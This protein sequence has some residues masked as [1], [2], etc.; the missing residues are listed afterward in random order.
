MQRCQ[1]IQLFFQHQEYEQLDDG[2]HDS[3]LGGVHSD[4]EEDNLD[5]PYCLKLSC[6]LL[7]ETVKGKKDFYIGNVYEEEV[8]ELGCVSDIDGDK[9]DDLHKMSHIT[10]DVKAVLKEEDDVVADDPRENGVLIEKAGNTFIN[11]FQILHDW[12][13]NKKNAGKSDFKYVDNPG[14]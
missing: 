10:K 2:D 3:E 9:C 5:D 11:C 6:Y 7:K 14:A 12:K 8:E 4:S 13:P 1:Q